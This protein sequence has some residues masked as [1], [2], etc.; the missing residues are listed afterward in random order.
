MSARRRRRTR[1]PAVPYD[2]ERATDLWSRAVDLRAEWL[3]HALRS[4]PA[5]R[6][7]AE[8]AIAG[9]YA[10]LDRPP[11]EFVWVG[12]P[13][14]AVSRAPHAPPV[15]F[16]GPLP[17]ENRLATLAHALRERLDHRIGAGA[18]SG[19]GLWLVPGPDPLDALRAGQPPRSVLGAGVSGVLRR[20]VKDLV[21]GT[22]RAELD[23]RLGLVWYGQHDVDRVAHYDAHRRLAGVR[24]DAADGEQLE[25]WAT[26]A[27][28]CGWWW[29]RDE[30][31]VVAERPAAVHTE[32]APGGLPHEV[33]L[34]NADGP[35]LRFPDGWAVYCWHGVRVPAWVIEAPTV[36]LIAAERNV[37]VR[38]CAI[39]RLGWSDFVDNAGLRLV[40]RAADPG[41][42]GSE[43]LLYDL[44]YQ[45]W[46]A[47]SRLLLAVNGSAER[48]GT[49]RR[50]GLRVPDWFDDPVDAAGWSYGLTGAQYAR[51]R[52]RT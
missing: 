34:H 5:D 29:P 42:P 14:A 39:E 23:R 15:D 37:E 36:E 11:P 7:A 25:L 22:V 4:G 13:A 35:A 30:V 12:S 2:P 52:R 18:G 8:H 40:G 38:R 19:S 10:L 50:Y 32:P 45:H 51:L 46:G 41:N 16:A 44:P 49:R 20:V 28:S 17:L 6:A 3:A 26:L 21:A 33:L 31:C 27:R 47:P 1:R 24:F 43:L 48:D 9:L